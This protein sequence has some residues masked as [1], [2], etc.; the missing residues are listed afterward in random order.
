MKKWKI[1]YITL[2]FGTLLSMVSCDFMDG[3]VAGLSNTDRL[4]IN[5]ELGGYFAG[6]KVIASIF[7]MD[8]AKGSVYKTGVNLDSQGNASISVMDLPD[9]QY[10][11]YVAVNDNSSDIFI[12]NLE[13][14]ASDI[15]VGKRDF[16]IKDGN[17]N[18]VPLTGG[19]MQKSY[20]G[21]V[22]GSG[23]PDS[24]FVLCQFLRQGTLAAV[25]YNLQTFTATEGNSAHA[26]AVTV[27]GVG[28]TSV[29]G[30]EAFFDST[31][32]SNQTYVGYDPS[33]K[34][35]NLV[36]LPPG[37]YDVACSHGFDNVFF[38]AGT[39]N[40]YYKE[41]LL[42]DTNGTPGH[43]GTTYQLPNDFIGP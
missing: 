35:G 31:T 22:H 26:L 10:T 30:Y 11:V 41:N 17:S 32:T 13:N 34:A 5:L 15:Q 39:D 36:A 23:L 37:Q 6:R 43:G 3:M 24:S 14:P 21:W 25:G 16:E 4:A 38:Q 18:E 29:P 27:M 8:K 19:D 1:I 7:P 33:R 20:M 12:N 28:P 42:I 40:N 2:I 9:G